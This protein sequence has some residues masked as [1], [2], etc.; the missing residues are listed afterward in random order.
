ML[1]G[2]LYFGTSELMSQMW[3]DRIYVWQML[4]F[5]DFQVSYVPN[6]KND[7]LRCIENIMDI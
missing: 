7:H 1:K 6:P 5:S 3:T 4:L 2:C